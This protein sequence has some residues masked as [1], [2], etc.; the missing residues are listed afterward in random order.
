MI[1]PEL[2]RRY[3]FFG[4]LPD[5]RLKGIAMLAEELHAAPGEVLCEAGQTAAWLFLLMRAAST[6]IWSSLRALA[7]G[8]STFEAH[9]YL[10]T[11]ETLQARL[12]HA[13][14]RLATAWA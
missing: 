13:R 1:S 8:D 11:A 10:K 5:S 7:E 9:L 6:C 12:G 2:V 3:A 4:R 14:V